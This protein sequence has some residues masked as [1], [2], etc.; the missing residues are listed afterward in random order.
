MKTRGPYIRGHSGECSQTPCHDSTRQGMNA[1]NC[2]RYPCW[3]KT[4]GIEVRFWFQAQSA[5]LAVSAHR[6]VTYREDASHRTTPPPL[7]H[8]CVLTYFESSIALWYN[9]KA[10]TPPYMRIDLIWKLD[11]SVIQPKGQEKTDRPTSP[12]NA[13]AIAGGHS[14]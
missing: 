14:K 12:G 10:K 8:T 7:P 5:V 1:L 3:Y 13:L 9:R 11:C 6:A 2:T 4:P